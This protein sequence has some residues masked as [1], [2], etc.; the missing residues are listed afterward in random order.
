MPTLGELLN[1]GSKK[2]IHVPEGFELRKL[3]GRD[4]L[5][6]N[7]LLLMSIYV[8]KPNGDLGRLC[9]RGS[10]L[11]W[12]DVM[13]EINRCVNSTRSEKYDMYLS[14]KLYNETVYRDMFHGI[15]SKEVLDEV[16]EISEKYVKEKES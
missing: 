5:V 2:L 12:D 8:K 6:P 11:D 1:L 13:R 4:K 3:N 16:I 15:V 9:Y 10:C 14:F 7:G